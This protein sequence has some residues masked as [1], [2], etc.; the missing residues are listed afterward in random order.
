VSCNELRPVHN[1]REFRHDLQI[2]GTIPCKQQVLA[3]SHWY[4]SAFSDSYGSDKASLVACF[5]AGTGALVNQSSL[6]PGVS[7][8]I[9]RG[10]TVRVSAAAFSPNA[11]P[12]LASAVTSVF[13]VH[14]FF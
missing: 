14:D 5:Q 13:I 12:R 7:C 9:I 4:T 10:G 6:P 2:T 3:P 1:S 11:L 8:D